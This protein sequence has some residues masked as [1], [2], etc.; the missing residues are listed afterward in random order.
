MDYERVDSIDS[1]VNGIPSS[2]PSSDADLWG[3]LNDKIN[4]DVLQEILAKMSQNAAAK[5]SPKV[6]V[7][8]SYRCVHY[9]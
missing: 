9:A 2:N 7:R 4:G 6:Q 5:A 3:Q 1:H 8:F